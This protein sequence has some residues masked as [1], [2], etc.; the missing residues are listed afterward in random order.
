[1]EIARYLAGDSKIVL[2]KYHENRLRIERE[3]GEKYAVQV[4]VMAGIR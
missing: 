1:M 2:A 3:I 4:N